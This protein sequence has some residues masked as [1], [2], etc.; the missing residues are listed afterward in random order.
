MCKGIRFVSVRRKNMNQSEIIYR[1]A[2]SYMEEHRMIPEHAFVAAGVSGGADS[3]VMLHILRRF[4]EK[5]NYRLAAVHVN[6]GIRGEE[7]ERDEEFVRSLCENWGVESA[8]YHYDVPNLASGS[9]LSTEEAGRIARRE[10]FGRFRG[11]R[12]PPEDAFFTALAHNI[13]DLGETVIHNLARGTGLRG[14]CS[15]KPASDGII[16]PVLC[17]SRDEILIYAGEN[18]IR[19]QTDSTNLSDEY[20]RN[21]IRR[22]VMPYLTENVNPQAVQH[23]AETAGMAALA[24][25][26]YELEL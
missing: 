13:N 19:Y 26:M 7:A 21:R 8:F 9:R 20:T 22:H 2:V 6:H 23:I 16:R 17:L 18:G 15:M 11:E 4:Q 24:M 12:V 5:K 10:A 3:V 1:K 14:L 25:I